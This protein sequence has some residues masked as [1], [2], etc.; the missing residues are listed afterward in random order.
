[1]DAGML[2]N[3][4]TSKIKSFQ[5]A[6]NDKLIKID[7]ITFEEKL[8]IVDNTLCNLTTW[9]D[10]ASL[11]QTL[12]TNLYLHDPNFIQDN[13]IKCFSVAILKITNLMRNKIITAGVFEEEDFQLMNYS[14]KFAPDF[15]DQTTL[16]SLKTAED[17]IAKNYRVRR[18][19]YYI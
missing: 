3:Q 9:L 6:I 19:Y 18:F 11:A 17:N 16:S 2:L 4:T 1:M 5:Q 12:F 13:Y 14:F 7:E 8:A 10:G 15:N